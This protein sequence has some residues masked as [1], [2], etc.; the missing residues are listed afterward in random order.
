MYSGHYQQDETD[1]VRIYNYARSAKQIVE[2]MNSGHPV[3]GSPV[4][5]SVAYYKMDE[6]Y[7]TSTTQ[8]SSQNNQDLTLSYGSGGSVPAWTTGGESGRALDFEKDNKSFTYTADS[9]ALS[10][11]SDLTVSAWI[12]PESVTGS[13]LF[14]IAGKWDGSNESF[15]LAQYGTELRMYIDASG[16]YKTTSGLGLAA[17]TWYYVAATYS[18]SSQTVSLYVNGIDKGGSVTGTIPTSIGDDGGRF[19]IGAEDSTTTAA[20]FYDG[21]IDEVKVYNSALTPDQITLDMNQGK[22]LQLGGQTSATGATGAAAEYCVPGDGS[23]CSPPVG[24][25]KFDEKTGGSVNDT[26]GNGKLGTWNGT[27]THWDRGEYGSAGSFNGSDDYVDIGA[28]PSTVKTVSF[29]AYPASTTEYFVDLNGSAYVWANAGTVNAQGFATPTIYV[30]GKASSTVTANTW[31][32]ISVTTAS[33]LNASDLD[34]GRLEGTDYFQGKIDQVTLYDYA[35]TPAQIAWDY[36]HGKPVGWWK[37]DEG[38]GDKAYDSSGNGN[39]GTLTSMDPPNDWVD[40]KFGKALDFDGSNDRVSGGTTG[41]SYSVGTISAWVN[42]SSTPASDQFVFMANRDSNRIY[43]LRLATSGNFGLRL[44]SS[45]NVDTGKVLPTSSW[46]HVLITWN[47]G[48]YYA[49]LNGNQVATGSYS[50]LS[51]IETCSSIGSY[52][53]CSDIRN[54]YFTGQIDDVRVYN[55][56]LTQT[57]VQQIMN[58]GSAI[59]FG[60]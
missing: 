16:N 4:G 40:G 19:Q 27:G 51:G 6:G 34:I 32:Y 49:Y 15:L 48:T 56:A 55:Y 14:D 50:G 59:R 30:N 33:G 1:D 52:D 31:Q 12:K 2:D 11:T 29:W 38:E 42:P 7:G 57:Q 24:E 35:R 47:L 44:G 28:G 3:G 18:A 54:S 37:M 43:L 20:N 58:E 23:T 39:T 26:S 25:W 13:T 53:N 10:I 21:I 22:E 17:G 36:N 41:F 45:S 5:S 46:S 9:T 8:D 60:D